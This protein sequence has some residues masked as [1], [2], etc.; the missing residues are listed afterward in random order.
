MDKEAVA[1]EADDEFSSNSAKVFEP[2]ARVGEELFSQRWLREHGGDVEA[3]CKRF[4]VRSRRHRRLPLLLFK[5]SQ[6]AAPFHFAVTRECR[7]L[8]LEEDTWKV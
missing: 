3:F 8:V 7:G 6:L 1:L 4:G 5:Y 2:S